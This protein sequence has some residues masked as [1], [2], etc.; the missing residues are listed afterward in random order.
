LMD[1]SLAS[2]VHMKAKMIMRLI[3]VLMVL[4][5]VAG[6]GDWSPFPTDRSLYAVA[7]EAV[8]AHPELPPGATVG[9]KRDSE[10]FVGK[11][12]ATIVIPYTTTSG[13]EGSFS[14]WLADMHHDWIV[15]RCIP[16]PSPESQASGA[17][18]QN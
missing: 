3:P 11:S 2:L 15:G 14:I 18:G 1:L 4:M 7:V 9:K 13:E 8:K 5:L 17:P 6:C 12:A 10:F 16:T